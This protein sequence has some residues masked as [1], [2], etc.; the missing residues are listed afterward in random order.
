MKE[1]FSPYGDLSKVELDGL[2][3]A[4]GNNDPGTARYSARVYFT[5]RH[6]AEKAFSTG[7]CW[8]GHNLQFSWLKSSN[9]S[10]DRANGESPLPTSKGHS[11][12]SVG[13]M[14]EISKTVSQKVATSG[15]GESETIE[16]KDIDKQDKETDESNRAT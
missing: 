16:Q 2:D 11:D 9:L 8:N 12:A 14:V 1:H 13:P 15:D 4:D 3:S 5:T 7:K 6:S 10:K